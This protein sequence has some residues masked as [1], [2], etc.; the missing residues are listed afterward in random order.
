[1]RD[2]VKFEK[3]VDEKVLKCYYNICRYYNIEE[4]GNIEHF[5]PYFDDT[6]GVLTQNSN[7]EYMIESI[8]DLVTFSAILNGGYSDENLEIETFPQ[9]SHQNIILMCDLDFKSELS[10]DNCET[11]KYNGYLG[12]EDEK[13]RYLSRH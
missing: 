10:Y 7:G 5:T 3:I 2:V 13:S 9:W 12:I 11:T 6:P 4:N 1:M 8:E